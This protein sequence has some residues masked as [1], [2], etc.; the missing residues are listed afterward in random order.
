[1]CRLTMFRPSTYTRSL[2]GSTRRIRPCL[3]RSLPAITWTWSPERTLSARRVGFVAVRAISE[4][5]WRQGHDLHEVAVTKF[6]RHGTKHAC[7]ARVVLVVN[8][9]RGVVI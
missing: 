5:L 6:A 1:M 9:H 3:P 4:H 2:A 7:T 8:D